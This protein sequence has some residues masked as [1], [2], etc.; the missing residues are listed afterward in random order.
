MSTALSFSS[1][2]QPSRMAAAM[3]ANLGGRADS[4]GWMVSDLTWV[5]MP[6][7]G[8]TTWQWQDSQGRQ[9]ADKITGLWVVAAEREYT[10]WNGTVVGGDTR[11]YLRSLDGKV[12][13]KVSHDPGDLDVSVIEKAKNADGTYRWQ[14]IPYCVFSDGKPPRA[15]DTV[16]AGILRDGDAMP[17]FVR[18]SRASCGEMERFAKSVAQSRGGLFHYEAVI[19]LSLVLKTTPRGSYSMV[20]PR[21][22]DTVSEEIG[23][24]AKQRFTIPLTPVVRPPIRELA[25]DVVPF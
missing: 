25:E 2:T 22:V 7:G 16:V 23:E 18:L 10:L 6:I 19:E 20:S 3:A 15:K 24:A 11:P 17:L 1:L 14:D 5:A 13:H 8:S 21:L 9:S 4:A 12:G